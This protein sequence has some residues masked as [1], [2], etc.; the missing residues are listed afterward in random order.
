MSSPVDRVER[1]AVRKYG[2]RGV[3]LWLIGIPWTLLGIAFIL[4]PQERFSRPGPGGSLDILD[5]PPGIYIFASM[6]LIGGIGAMACA[7]IRPRICVDDWGFIAAVMPPFL[8]GCGFFWSQFAY[9]IS[10][11]EFGRESA[12]FAMIVYWSFSLLLAFLSKRL[13]DSPEGP[14]WGRR[15]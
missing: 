4:Q 12:Y 8:W 15:R 11:G 9:I 5:N 6:W 10:G 1:L 2:T 7:A 3:C 13:P 14:C